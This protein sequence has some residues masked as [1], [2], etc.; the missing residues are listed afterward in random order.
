MEQQE[1]R[2]SPKRSQF[3][4]KQ[5]FYGNPPEMQSPRSLPVGKAAGVIYFDTAV[6]CRLLQ[7]ECAVCNVFTPAGKVSS[8]LQLK[9]AGV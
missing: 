3:S 2:H 6:T 1:K 4:A 9:C 5:L 8:L 7:L